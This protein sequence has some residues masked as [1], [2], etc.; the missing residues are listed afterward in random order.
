[1][2]YTLI[3]LFTALLTYT[4][5]SFLFFNSKNFMMIDK[6]EFSTIDE[7]FTFTCIPSKGRDYAMMKRTFDAY[8]VKNNKTDDLKVYRVTAKNYFKISSWCWYKTSPEWNH[9]YLSFWKR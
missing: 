8:K 6:I 5:V 2:K 3:I 4:A 1:M 7:D 9:E